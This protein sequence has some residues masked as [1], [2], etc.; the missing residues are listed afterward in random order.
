MLKVPQEKR[1]LSQGAITME[2]RN[3]DLLNQALGNITL[4]PAEQQSLVWLAGWETST[5]KHVISAFEKA[6][7]V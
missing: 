4:T 1:N 7:G 3:L 6:K 2:Q 5:V